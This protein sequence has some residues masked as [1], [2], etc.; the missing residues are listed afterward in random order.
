VDPGRARVLGGVRALHPRARP[1][2]G[3]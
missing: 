1:A 2:S 3:P